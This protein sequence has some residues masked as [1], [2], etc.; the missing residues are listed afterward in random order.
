VDRR[1]ISLSGGRAAQQTQWQSKLEWREDSGAERRDQWVTTHRWLHKL[2]ESLRLAARLNYSETDDRIDTDAGARFMESNI[3]FAWRPAQSSRHALLGKYTFLYDVSALPQ[4]GINVA[5]FDQRSHVLALE[6]IYQL[7]RQW[8]FA[9]KVM[10]REGEVRFGRFEGQWTDSATSFLAGQARY[11]LADVW[12]GLV[13]YRWL[14]VQDGGNRQGALIGVDRDIGER[15]RI[16]A[17]YNFTDFSDDL[18]D[19]DY[20]HQGWYFNLVGKY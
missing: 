2:S 9:S 1:A 6:G 3:G 15:L 18:T 16:G 8:E 13:E 7:D 10:R 14:G 11:R 12:Y 19:F 20:D 5:L 17:G 4:T